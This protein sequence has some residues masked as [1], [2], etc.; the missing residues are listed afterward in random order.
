M[1]D[2][3]LGKDESLLYANTTTH[4]HPI[5]GKEMSMGKALASQ[6]LRRMGRAL[7][8]QLAGVKMIEEAMRVGPFMG[9]ET[10]QV[11]KRRPER[12]RR[13]GSMCED[14]SILLCLID[15]IICN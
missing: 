4:H 6:Q 12:R 1:T 10:I 15:L 5:G 8:K 9:Q 14:E 13:G 3:P 2:G 11:G 7:S